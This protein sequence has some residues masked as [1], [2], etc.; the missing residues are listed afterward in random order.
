MAAS[1]AE[2]QEGFLKLQQL[3]SRQSSQISV[4]ERSPRATRSPEKLPE[5]TPEQ[6]EAESITRLMSEGNYEQGTMQW[7]QSNRT[8]E[9]FDTVFVRCNPAYLNRVSPLLA[10]S[11]GAVVTEALEHNLTER[12]IWLDAV[13]KNVDPNVSPPFRVLSLHT[14]N[15]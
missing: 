7:L 12:L 2:L 13:L 14:N 15:Y 11:T 8:S 6:L 4:V 5:K 10:L 3:L 1:Q 9:L